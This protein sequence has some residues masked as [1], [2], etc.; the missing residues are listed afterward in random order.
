MDV[1]QYIR[2]SLSEHGIFITRFLNMLCAQLKQFLFQK[3]METFKKTLGEASTYMT[4]AVQVNNAVHV[5]DYI[6]FEC[7]LAQ[8]YSFVFVFLFCEG[9]NHKL[10]TI[11]A[12]AFP[13][14]FPDVRCQMYLHVMSRLFVRYSHPI[15]LPQLLLH[16]LRDGKQVLKRDGLTEFDERLP[17]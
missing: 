13:F 7:N 9:I 5:Y 15:P 2:Q 14:C 4:R 8:R 17:S 16:K 12:L 1:N 3:R 10:N 11:T 6:S